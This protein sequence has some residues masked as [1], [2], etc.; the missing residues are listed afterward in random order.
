M[1]EDPASNL[2]KILESPSYRVAYKDVD[3][4]MRPEMRAARIELELLKPELYFQQQRHPL[5]GRRL[6]QHADRRAGGRPAAARR[7]R[8]RAGRL[9]GRSAAPAGGRAGRN[10]C[11]ERSRYYDAA[12]EFA[13]LVSA[14]ASGQ[15]A[16][17]TT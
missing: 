10:T 6:R 9:A 3:F 15:V 11:V 8:A 16:F 5:D 7:G 2:S 17:A 4:L 14:A 1:T 13:R 12:R